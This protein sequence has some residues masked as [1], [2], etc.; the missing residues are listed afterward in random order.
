VSYTANTDI[1]LFIQHKVHYLKVA[2]FKPGERTWFVVLTDFWPTP[3][4]RVNQQPQSRCIHTAYHVHQKGFMNQIFEQSNFK[5]T[6]E[7]KTDKSV[8][9]QYSR[10]SD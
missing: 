1:R 5:G 7:I 4:L 2:Y 9:E 10:Y 8:T 3:F 6:K